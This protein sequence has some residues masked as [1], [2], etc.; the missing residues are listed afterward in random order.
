MVD[1]LCIADIDRWS[2][3]EINTVFGTSMDVKN[4]SLAAADQLGSLSAFQSW[5]G[6]AAD[7]A[8][9]SVGK[10]RADLDRH[11]E[12]AGKVADAARKAEADIIA[13]R[14]RLTALRAEADANGLVIDPHTDTVSDPHP[15]DMQGWAEA[16]K[17]AYYNEITDLQRRVLELLVAADTADGELASAI[18][19]AMGGE[20]FTWKPSSRDLVLS[21]TAATQ[22]AGTDI[23][24]DIWLKGIGENP[25]DLD[26]KVIPWIADIGK[27]KGLSGAGGAVGVLTAVPAVFSDHYNDDESW[28]ESIAREGAG[29]AAGVATDAGFASAGESLATIA[30]VG[31]ASGEAAADGAV[32]GSIV[33]GPGT[34]AGAAVGAVAGAVAAYFT[35]KG[36]EKIW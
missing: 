31:A 10:T 35:S 26:K 7:A 20:P 15:P 2:I 32:I 5:R 12:K 16:D 25:T 21:G 28:G 14:H 8:R 19:Q 27:V 34:V 23:V 36:V 30:G 17:V 29:T 11:G 1:K 13:V 24:R 33:P 22:S 4:H 9:E 6:P 18:K 3:G